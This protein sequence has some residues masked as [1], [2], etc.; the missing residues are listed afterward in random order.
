MCNV[1]DLQM[2][3]CLPVSL[4]LCVH[5]VADA[6]KDLKAQIA[7]L[8]EELEGLRKSAA[9]H[10][11]QMAQP[12]GPAHAAGATSDSDQLD[13]AERCVRTYINYVCWG[14][15][16]EMGLV[17]CVI[18]PWAVSVREL[19]SQLESLR[20]R[21]GQKEAEVERMEDE[22]AHKDSVIRVSLR[23]DGTCTH[24]HTQCIC[25]HLLHCNRP[26]CTH[27]Q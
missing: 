18:P 10:A 9:N 13:E 15:G 20:R 22:L 5:N 16:G 24:T 19:R 2:S 23:E 4:Y 25:T 26:Y 6:E 21:L 3:F 27:V 17:N 7:S 8:E 14:R 11:S 12:R 1:T